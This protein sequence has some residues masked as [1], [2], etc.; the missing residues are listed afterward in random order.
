MAT[1]SSS[2]AASQGPSFG[3]GWQPRDRPRS[4]LFKPKSPAQ[5]QTHF[6]GK[7]KRKSE[8][9]FNFERKEAAPPWAEAPHGKEVAPRQEAAPPRSPIGAATDSPSAGLL[10][11]IAKA[12]NVNETQLSKLVKPELLENLQTLDPCMVMNSLSAVLGNLV[13]NVKTEKDEGDVKYLPAPLA[14]DRKSKGFSVAAA[15]AE[16]AEMDIATSTSGDEDEDSPNNASARK[17]VISNP[18]L[19]SAE[20]PGMI[21]SLVPPPQPPRILLPNMNQPPPPPPQLPFPAP[22]PP[23]AQFANAPAPPPIPVQMLAAP[24]PPHPH[25]FAPPVRITFGQGPVVFDYSAPPPPLSQMNPPLPMGG[26]S[27]FIFFN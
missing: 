4:P 14:P 5:T 16:E 24:A 10:E 17:P 1:A 22:P 2:A 15:A 26:E 7:K 23:V 27:C 18:I 13:K 21:S 11:N 6:E 8:K 25:N 19:K 12:W 3:D 9:T 20:I